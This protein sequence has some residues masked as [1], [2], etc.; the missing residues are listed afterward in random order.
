M[1]LLASLAAIL[2]CTKMRLYRVVLR[3]IEPRFFG[4]AGLSVGL[5]ILTLCIFVFS[6][7]IGL[8]TVPV[9]FGITLWLY[10]CASRLGAQSFFIWL[11]TWMGTREKVLIYGAGAAGYCRSPL[12]IRHQSKNCTPDI[13]NYFWGE[14]R[15]PQ[16]RRA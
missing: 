15:I 12:R 13:G 10:L 16:G 2:V 6:F 14:G 7:E 5:L 1:F 11:T 9:I 3:A 8:G 4:L